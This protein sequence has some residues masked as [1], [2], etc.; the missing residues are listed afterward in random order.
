V[1]IDIANRFLRVHRLVEVARVEVSIIIDRPPAAVWRHVEDIAS[2]VEWMADAES[3]RFTSESTRGVGTSFDCET[4]VGPFRLTDRMTVTEWVPGATM[5]VSHVG[6]VTG[7]GR[8][9]L[10]PVGHGRTEF[11][12]AEDLT[13]PRWMAGRAG[14][15][16]GRPVLTRIWRGNL[17]RLKELI[18]AA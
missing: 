10:R 8:F 17:R 3:I 13:F 15:F 16:V 6:V 11:S 12:W 4:K 7:T 2:H 14:A 5:G 9:R 1:S 18:E